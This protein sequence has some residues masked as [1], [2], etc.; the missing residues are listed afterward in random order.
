MKEKDLT[1]DAAPEPVVLTPRQTEIRELRRIIGGAFVLRDDANDAELEAARERALEVRVDQEAQREASAD[2]TVVPTQFAVNRLKPSLRVKLRAL[3]P[4]GGGLSS[5]LRAAQE[6]VAKAEKEKELLEA[7]QAA[8]FAIDLEYESMRERRKTLAANITRARDRLAG[9]KA[10]VANLTAM[11]D[12]LYLAEWNDK[13]GSDVT[14][15]I[16]EAVSLRATAHLIAS[17]EARL[18]KSWASMLADADRD[19]EAFKRLHSL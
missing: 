8:A 1:T 17:D 16:Y 10:H 13:F 6:K 12:G 4:G 19:I 18:E 2:G 5:K 9:A 3:L 15:A 7:E 11:L 14:G